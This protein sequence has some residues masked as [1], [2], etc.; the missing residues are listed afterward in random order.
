MLASQFG[1]SVVVDHV[2]LT[3][4]KQGGFDFISKSFSGAGYS[5]NEKVFIDFMGC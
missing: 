2:I 5:E 3:L 1:V 4:S